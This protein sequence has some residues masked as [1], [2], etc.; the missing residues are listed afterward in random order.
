MTEIKESV[1][2]HYTRIIIQ[3]L[4]FGILKVKLKELIELNLTK[5]KILASNIT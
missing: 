1:K 2:K 5:L 4:I 3:K